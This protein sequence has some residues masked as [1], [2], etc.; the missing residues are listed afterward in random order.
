VPTIQFKGKSVIESYHHTVPH[1][2]LEFDAKLS[3]LPKGERPS[4]DGN[5]IIEGDNLLALKALLPTHAGRVKCIYI[6][7]PYNT[8]NEGWVYNDNLTQPQFKEWIGRTVGKE[9]EDACRHDK[10]CCM[11]YPRLMLLKELLYN[12]GLILVSTDDNEIA[13]LRLIMDEVFDEGNFAASFIW[14]TEGHTDNQAHVKVNHQYVIA[15][16][17]N[18]NIL[19]LEKVI[20]P[21]TPEESNLRR[22][23]AENSIT[24]NGSGNPA[25]QI[26]LPKD[27]PCAVE[28]LR[29]PRSTVPVD[30]FNEVERKGWISRELTRRYGITY[31]VRLSPMVVVNGKLTKPCKVFSGWANANKLREYIDGDCNPLPEDGGSL[32]FYLSSG[33]VIYYKRY[34]DAA[35][36]IL[37]VLRKVGTTEQARYE[38]EAMGLDFPYPKP[39]QL[40][41]YLVS[42]GAGHNDIVLD[43][44]AGSGTTGHA[45][46][47]M[48]ATRGAER[49]FVLIQQPHDTVDDAQEEFNICSEVTAE[50]IRHA[51]QGYRSSKDD[52]EFEGLGGSYTYVR[53]GEPL[54]GEYKDFGDELPAY[55]DIAKYVFYTETSHEFP[56]TTKKQNPGWDKK[57]GRIGEHAGRSYYLLYEPNEREDRGL[58]RAFLNDVASQD[59]NRELVVYCE[60]LAVHQDELRKFHREHGKRIRHMLVPFNLK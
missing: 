42:L 28:E 49:R 54:F 46:L 1:H 36:N 15:Y 16:A 48:N 34:R 31:P 26:T 21:N 41:S 2:R 12:T 30:F 37:S 22:G 60:R 8:G 45:I 5:L 9:G 35:R 32:T 38:L 14:N 18:L 7:P 44:T 59:P 3:L 43:A 13:S 33:G 29:L 39:R 17:K 47:E 11:M 58:D 27:F 23:F 24:K 19:E 25:A 40:I 57:S 20:D 52:T 4:L 55:E 51:S 53:L 50:R 6:D 56:G 10:W